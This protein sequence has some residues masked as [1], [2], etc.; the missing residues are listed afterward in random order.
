MLSL[1]KNFGYVI[2]EWSQ[3]IQSSFNS[4]RDYKTMKH[5]IKAESHFLSSG[6]RSEDMVIETN[7]SL[8]KQV[9]LLLKN[10]FLNIQGQQEQY[11]VTF[12]YS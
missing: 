8:W 11:S 1:P 6:T 5:N 9:E 4:S 7:D 10:N 12:T 3:L 2:N